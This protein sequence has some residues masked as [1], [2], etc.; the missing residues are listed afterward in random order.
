MLFLVGNFDKEAPAKK[1]SRPHYDMTD[2]PA[3]YF[4]IKGGD[5][6]V[7]T[8]PSGGKGSDLVKGREL[9][10]L[11]NTMTTMVCC[12]CAPLSNGF[13]T[14]PSGLAAD[15]AVRRAIGDIAL[16]W[17]QLFLQG[18]ESARSRLLER[19]GIASNFE[20]KGI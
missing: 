10:Y 4:E 5:H 2:A 6:C 20:S 1:H 11:F 18:D 19:P 15:G 7:V 17:L 12:G 9:S 16:A 13:A 14:G 3:L 8:G